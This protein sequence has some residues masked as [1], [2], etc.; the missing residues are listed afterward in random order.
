MGHAFLLLVGAS[1]LAAL[2]GVGVSRKWG[3]AP[4]LWVMA[5]YT[6]FVFVL[7]VGSV[8][9]FAW[10]GEGSGV[11][12]LGI[13]GAIATFGV[14]VVVWIPSLYGYASVVGGLTGKR[15]ADGLWMPETGNAG[16]ERYGKMRS[17]LMQGD[18]SGAMR[19]C[20]EAYQRDTKKPDA[21]FCGAALFS[22]RGFY[23]DAE[24]LYRQIMNRFSA[25]AGV[26]LRAAW[27]LSTMLEEGAGRRNDAILLWRQ[28]V[29]RAPKSEAGRQAGNKLHRMSPLPEGINRPQV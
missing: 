5:G 17:L 22:G 10:G 25:D 1:L 20:L 29:R 8:W 3:D 28:I 26:W 6:I 15:V 27:E 2:A 7:G 14:V 18:T 11:G 12:G 21:L 4:P 13:G 23:G 16:P 19:E 9:N 24:T